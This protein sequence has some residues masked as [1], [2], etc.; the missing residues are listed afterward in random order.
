ML[1][2]PRCS[3]SN[4]TSGSFIVTGSA[5]VMDP[6]GSFGISRVRTFGYLADRVAERSV[7]IESFEVHDSPA[8]GGS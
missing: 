8:M 7:I 3:S 2:M 4:G 1:Y 6:G 5:P